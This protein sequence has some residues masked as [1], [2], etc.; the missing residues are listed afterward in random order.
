MRVFFT[1][2]RMAGVRGV[3]SV[4]QILRY[5]MCVQLITITSTLRAPYTT[6][7]FVLKLVTT[8]IMEPMHS[9]AEQLPWVSHYHGITCHPATLPQLFTADLCLKVKLTNKFAQITVIRT[10][11]GMNGNTTTSNFK[12]EH[13]VAWTRK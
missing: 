13:Y 1:I 7:V 10:L 3:I 12:P 4:S 11:C 8:D 6:S 5:A 2:I 9:G